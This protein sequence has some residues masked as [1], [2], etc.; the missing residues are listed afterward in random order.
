MTASKLDNILLL[1]GKC[2]EHKLLGNQANSLRWGIVFSRCYI[3][4]LMKV[5][6]ERAKIKLLIRRK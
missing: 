2:L 5:A 1:T 4:F 3:A 6:E